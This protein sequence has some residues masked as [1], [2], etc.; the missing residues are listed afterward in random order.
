ML[1]TRQADR[2]FKLAEKLGAR[3]V[4][5]GDTG[6]HHSVERGQAFDLLQKFGGMGV[7]QVTEIQRQSGQ[8]KEVVELVAAGKVDEAFAMMEK[9]GWIKEMTVEQRQSVLAQDYLNAIE[10]GKTALVVAP[11][12]AECAEVTTGIRKELRERQKLKG[13]VAWEVLRDLSWTEAQK[14][15]WGHYQTG[16][17]VRF[18]GHVKGFA[19]GERVEV[20][21]ADGGAVRVR[22]RGAFKDQI[23]LLPLTEPDKFNVY[24]PDKIEISEGERIRVRINTRTAD[25][26]R[27]SNGNLYTVDYIDHQ[28]RLVLSNGWKLGRDFAHLEYGYTLTSHGAQ[29]KTVD[30]VFVAQ[31]AKF[32]ALASDLAQ[33]YVAI[34]RGRSLGRL[35]CDS[36]EAVRELVS[37]ARERPMA[38][39]LLNESQSEKRAAGIAVEQ[40][41]RLADALG[42][43]KEQSPA[44]LETKLLAMRY[45]QPAAEPKEPE[46]ELEME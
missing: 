36:I 38:M 3:L 18:N 14:S 44:D 10:A 12:R 40:P 9:L 19:L 45:R 5:V 11:T 33:F 21:G 35:Y 13:G 26:H 27:V 16:Q 22:S 37:V 29:S 6:Q 39:E 32:S 46:L 43:T 7:A 23:K 15:D 8:Y 31:T 25:G 24:E 2:L 30:C 28:Q 17:V 1:S 20:L 42:Q 4:L 34:S 41:M